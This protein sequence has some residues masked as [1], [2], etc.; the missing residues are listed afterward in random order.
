MGISSLS[1]KILIA[2]VAIIVAIYLKSP[3]NSTV[4]QVSFMSSSEIYEFNM[5]MGER[6]TWS[7]TFLSMNANSAPYVLSYSSSHL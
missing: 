5:S 2:C 7:E 3:A 4:Y 6:V 1:T